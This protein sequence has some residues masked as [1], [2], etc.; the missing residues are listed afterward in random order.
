MDKKT[1]TQIGLKMK[2]SGREDLPPTDEA[3]GSVS[4]TARCCWGSRLLDPTGLN[5][6]RLETPRC[7]EVL[8]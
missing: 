2:L 5:H 3:L 1:E 8:P 4:R 7:R 6:F